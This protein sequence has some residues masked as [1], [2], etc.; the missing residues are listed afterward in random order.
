[1]DLSWSEI[2]KKYCFIFLH[3]TQFS[4]AQRNYACKSN[5]FLTMTERRQCSKGRS[6]PPF[7]A[8]SLPSLSNDFCFYFKLYFNKKN[9][10]IKSWEF[11]FFFENIKIRSWE[12]EFFSWISRFS[13]E[14]LNIFSDSQDWVL[15]FAFFKI[16]I[17]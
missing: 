7:A 4:K 9:L 14:N 6:F 11:E 16:K 13:L 5:F 12:S 1:M 17:K 10:K 8:P 3:S 2:K 15:R